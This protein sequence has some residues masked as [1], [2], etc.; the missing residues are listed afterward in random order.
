MMIG[1]DGGEDYLQYLL[2]RA[3]SLL[4]KFEAYMRTL[5]RQFNEA[6]AQ[7]E[8]GEG[9]GGGAGVRALGLDEETWSA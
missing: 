7:E 5:T 3:E 4:P 1:E 6:V 8:E 9:G 2:L